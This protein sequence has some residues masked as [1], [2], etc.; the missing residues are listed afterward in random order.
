MSANIVKSFPHSV[1]SST[2]QS[3]GVKRVLVGA[4]RPLDSS[5]VSI[6]AAALRA[7]A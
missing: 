1:E 6:V 3:A 5:V 2:K 7:A 4:K